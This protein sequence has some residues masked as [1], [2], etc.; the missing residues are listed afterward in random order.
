MNNLTNNI[1]NS[2][3]KGTIDDHDTN[4][5]EET[6]F[7]NFLFENKSFTNQ[8]ESNQM[9]TTSATSPFA[10]V[11][12]LLDDDLDKS[13]ISRARNLLDA[14]NGISNNGDVVFFKDFESINF[15]F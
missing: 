2:Q 15:L 11:P 3:V 4:F 14:S 5:N 1:I 6:H 12:N 10:V 8:D 9:T 13:N 7:A